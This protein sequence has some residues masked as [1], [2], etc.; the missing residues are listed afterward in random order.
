MRHATFEQKILSLWIFNLAGGN[1]GGGFSNMNSRS[2]LAVPFCIVHKFTTCTFAGQPK[3]SLNLFQKTRDV[4]SLFLVHLFRFLGQGWNPKFQ[5][6]INEPCCN[7]PCIEIDIQGQG[8]NID[9]TYVQQV[10][11]NIIRY[12]VCMF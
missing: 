1:S 6:G 2:S 10:K 12:T 9:I 7:T 3:P 8:I 4:P 11:K 5:V